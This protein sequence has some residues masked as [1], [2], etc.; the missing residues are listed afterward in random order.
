MK[1]NCE[2]VQDLLVLYDEN[3]CSPAS[4]EAVERHLAEC[5]DC[6]KLRNLTEAVTIPEVPAESSPED[7]AAV[8]TIRRMRRKWLTSLIAVLLLIPLLMLSFNQIVGMNVCFTNLDEIMAA[9]RFVELLEA[10]DVETAA[11]MVDFSAVYQEARFWLDMG[12]EQFGHSDGFQRF[13]VG[14]VVVY[15]SRVY[16]EQFRD[17]VS[18]QG[19]NVWLYLAQ[20]GS[21]GVPIPEAGWNKVLEDD[22]SLFQRQGDRFLGSDGKCFYEVKTV[23]GTLY[24][25]E[26]TW[27]A[28]K[29]ISQWTDATSQAKQFVERMRLIPGNL[30]EPVREEIDREA[31]DAYEELQAAYGAAE[32]LSEAE[33]QVRMTQRYTQRL[34]AYLDQG[35]GV[36]NPGY[37]F[38]RAMDGGWLVTLNLE[39]FA[40]EGTGTMDM[41]IQIREGMIVDIHCNSSGTNWLRE[42]TRS[43]TL[44]YDLAP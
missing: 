23:W 40:P 32:G 2:I 8:K 28:W 30:F 41:R 33:F 38:S 44:D 12:P 9:Y 16:D 1:M 39:V 34:Q 37:V 21:G 35:Y 7:R 19:E 36:E 22:P 25:D 11:E 17:L 29:P 6:R 10:G 13:Q 3:M 4:R 42:F 5:P 31:M 15:A 24:M 26:I 18:A 27:E 43:L 14:D 20:N